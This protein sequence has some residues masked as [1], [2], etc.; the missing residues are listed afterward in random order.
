MP[1]IS[2][3]MER[4]SPPRFMRHSFRPTASRATEGGDDRPRVCGGLLCARNCPDKPMAAAGAGEPMFVFKS[5]GGTVPF[6]SRA[7]PD[8]P[9][10]G[11]LTASDA[12]DGR[13]PSRGASACFAP[14]VSQRRSFSTL[15]QTTQT[16]RRWLRQ[17]SLSLSLRTLPKFPYA[18]VAD[19]LR[20]SLRAAATAG[21]HSHR[22]PLSTVWRQVALTLGRSRSL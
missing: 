1:R 5:F 2:I 21:R 18:D 6:W 4:P 9:S 17:R 19:G 16:V 10:R 11:G 7:G 20:V 3:R 14:S 22:A 8:R 15:L 13:L 12:A